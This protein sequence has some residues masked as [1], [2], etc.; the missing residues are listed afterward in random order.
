ME[1]IELTT[2]IGCPCMCEYCAQD[3]IL[4]RYNSDVKELTLENTKRYFSTIPKPSIVSIAGF[5]EP[6]RCKEIAEILRYLVEEGHT[7]WVFSTLYKVP[8]ATIRK[9]FSIPNL[10]FRLH[11]P[12]T[13]GYT[14]IVL[15]DELTGNFNLAVKLIK[16]N[17]SSYATC[18]WGDTP[19][20]L[21]HITDGVDHQTSLNM[22]TDFAGNVTSTDLV[23]A[24]PYKTGKL[25]CR[26]CAHRHILPDGRISFCAQDWSLD[27]L[28]GDLNTQT[29][30]E[31][32][33]GN[34]YLTYTG[35]CLTECEDTLCRKC[36]D[37]EVLKE[38]C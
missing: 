8:K 10:F 5:S 18:C 27:Y 24:T 23:N 37:S 26:R 17:G 38:D 9:V 31:I 30:S 15:D 3:M 13:N 28:I 4:S 36:S 32:I 35:N 22:L 14:K 2:K 34:N 11:L 16:H 12:D 1:R 33:N 25:T 29:Y 7:V 6:L 21:T 20:E 19:T